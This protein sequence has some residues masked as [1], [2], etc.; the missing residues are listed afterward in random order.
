MQKNASL[1]RSSGQHASSD[2]VDR[3]ITTFACSNSMMFPGQCSRFVA[4]PNEP[5]QG[6][7]SELPSFSSMATGQNQLHL[8]CFANSRHLCQPDLFSTLCR[9]KPLVLLKICRIHT[10][11]TAPA[12]SAL[13]VPPPL[14]EAGSRPEGQDL[15]PPWEEGTASR[16]ATSSTGVSVQLENHF[17]HR[18][19]QVGL[20]HCEQ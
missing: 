5:H 20:I 8:I 18:E 14:W 1:A 16:G 6:P 2:K 9:R 13:A 15:P 10:I 4:G 11:C 12:H 17:H 3:M 19:E 7:G